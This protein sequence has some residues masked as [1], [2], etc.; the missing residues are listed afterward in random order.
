MW[1]VEML[2]AEQ[3]QC[4]AVAPQPGATAAAG[5]QADLDSWQQYQKARLAEGCSWL[6][7][8]RVYIR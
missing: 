1:H 6:A 7:C 3:W 8:A 2:P 5:R 4:F